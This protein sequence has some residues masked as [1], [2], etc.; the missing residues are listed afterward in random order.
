MPEKEIYYH[1]WVIVENP[2]VIRYQKSVYPH[3]AIEDD[4]E[5]YAKA[6]RFYFN[7]IR[8]FFTEGINFEKGHIIFKDKKKQMIEFTKILD[9]N[10]EDIG[11]LIKAFNEK[12][13]NQKRNIL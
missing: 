4:A 2:R 5:P 3:K 1:G 10:L 6:D 7:D 13:K 9:I 11:D 12:R 8:C